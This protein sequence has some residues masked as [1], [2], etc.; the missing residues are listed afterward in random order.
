MEHML[1]L[2][3]VFGYWFSI[4][5]HIFFPKLHAT[6]AD[7]PD[8]SVTNDIL[9]NI[10]TDVPSTANFEPKITSFN[11][12]G[13]YGFDLVYDQASYELTIKV[14]YWSLN[15]VEL[16]KCAILP[17]K[18][19]H[20][21]SSNISSM[22]AKNWNTFSIWQRILENWWRIKGARKNNVFLSHMQVP[23][24]TDECL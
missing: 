23:S 4:G 12:Q 17:A 8:T 15:Y 20:N 21:S 14:R 18:L 1:M 13:I 22:I 5:A 6:K 16:Q 9:L 10:I 7:K 11:T 24:W 3:T 19:L 2:Q